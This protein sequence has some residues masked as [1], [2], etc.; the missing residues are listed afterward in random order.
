[1]EPTLNMKQTIRAL[2]KPAALAYFRYVRA[3]LRIR[4]A[5]GKRLRRLEIGPSQRRL[6]GFETLDIVPGRH[7]DYVANALLQL[8]FHDETFDVVYAS[9][10][11]EHLPWFESENVLR[12]WRR[13]LKLNGRLEIWVP[14]GE[15][16][17]ET[18]LNATRGDQVEDDGWRVRNPTGDPFLWANGRLF[19]GVNSHYPSWHKAVFTRTSLCN[20]L[21][22]AGFDNVRQAHANEYRGGANEG[23][24]NLGVLGIRTSI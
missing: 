11:L 8:P 15:Y 17:A 16:I 2:A 6:E 7:V 18:I 9:H 5:A 13:V 12:E 22:A 1:M 20:L 23:R 3:P 24:I 10:V 19:Y 4:A 14:N 21:Q